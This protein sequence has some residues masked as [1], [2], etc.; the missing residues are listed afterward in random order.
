MAGG[1]YKMIFERELGSTCKTFYED[2]LESM[3][4]EFKVASNT[5]WEWKQC[6]LPVETIFIN[7]W[8]PSGEFCII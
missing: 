5:T 4:T 2:H 8:S 1:Q 3:H 7:D 6:P